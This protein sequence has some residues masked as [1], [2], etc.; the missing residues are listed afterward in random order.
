[1]PIYRFRCSSCEKEDDLLVNMGTEKTICPECGGVTIKTFAAFS[2]SSPRAESDFKNLPDAKAWDYIVG[3]QADRLRKEEIP[4]QVNVKNEIV[5][6][7]GMATYKVGSSVP[8]D[9]V[10]YSKAS[11]KEETFLKERKKL[12]PSIAKAFGG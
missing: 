8:D 9:Q 3:T 2:V 6:S 12:E 10:G 11:Q 1:M 5:K 7:G 4:R